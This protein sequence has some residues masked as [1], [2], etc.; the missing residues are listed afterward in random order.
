MEGLPL[1]EGEE[2]V[3]VTVSAYCMD[4]PIVNAN[5]VKSITMITYRGGEIQTS[6]ETKL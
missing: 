4:S 6:P 1:R 3:A 2:F 5:F